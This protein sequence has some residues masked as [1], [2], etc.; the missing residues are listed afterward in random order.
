VTTADMGLPDVDL[1]RALALVGV[2]EH[3]E[4]ERKQRTNE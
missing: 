3:E 1:D 2:L 4:L